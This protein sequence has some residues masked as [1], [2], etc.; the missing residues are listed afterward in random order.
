[1]PWIRKSDGGYEWKKG[2]N[3][4][5]VYRKM[6]NVVYTKNKV[7]DNSPAK[8]QTSSRLQA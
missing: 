1:M 6:I 5:R 7:V 3:R 8:K 2:N 4:P